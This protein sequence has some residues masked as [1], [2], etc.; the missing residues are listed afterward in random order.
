[1]VIYKEYLILFGGINNINGTWKGY[2]DIYIYDCDN[3]IWNKFECNNKPRKRYWHGMCIVNSKLIVY[4]GL[5]VDDVHVNDTYSINVDNIINNNR[6]TWITVN[7]NIPPLCAHLLLFNQDKLYCFG[8]ENQNRRKHTENNDLLIYDTNTKNAH[9][10]KEVKPRS[11]HNGCVIHWNNMDCIFVFG[12]AKSQN[13]LNDTFLIC[14]QEN[15]IPITNGMELND[16]KTIEIKYNN[17]INELKKQITA[18][19]EICNDLVKVNDETKQQIKK[20]QN[21]I[22]IL[23]QNNNHFMTKITDLQSIKSKYENKIQSLSE[24]IS[25][26]QKSEQQIKNYQNEIKLLKENNSA[27]IK[28]NKQYLSK[29]SKLEAIKSEYENKIQL[30]SKQI[31]NTDQKSEQK[32]DNESIKKDESFKDYFLKTFN[33]IKSNKIYY[34]NLI[35]NELNSIESL[36]LIENVG[37]INE[38]IKPKN[39]IHANLLLKKIKQIKI[40]RNNFEE[41]LKIINMYHYLNVFD[42][43][44]IYTLNEYYIK[45][46]TIND[47]KSITKDDA[48]SSLIFDSFNKNRNIPDNPEG[49]QRTQQF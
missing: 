6:P 24:Q 25:N 13:W 4:G 49:Q 14:I 27:S 26:E 3:N 43:Y 18:S 41:K 9:Q 11:G 34:D 29:I 45:I 16:M 46:K 48:L 23:N 21:E 15:D 7:T 2:N 17:E 22:K 12:G 44:G 1:M 42:E 8:G 20:Y 30:L 28:L 37:D 35:E 32:M 19:N 40:D 33:N 39:K 36:I 47:L 38:Y 5:D 31:N 10:I